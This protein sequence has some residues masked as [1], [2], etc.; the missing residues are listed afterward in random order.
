MAKIL[1]VEDDHDVAILIKM[2]L[3][4]ENHVVEV[5]GDGLLAWELL[6]TYQYEVVILDWQLPGMSGIE[7]CR[8]FRLTKATTPVLMLTGRGAVVDRT[9]GL[10][11]GADDYLTKPFDMREVSARVRALVRRFGN[12]ATNQVLC[13]DMSFDLKAKTLTVGGEPIKLLP[14]ELSLIEF[15]MRNPNEVFSPEA[16]LERVWH[17]ESQVSI[18][19]VYT[20]IK[21]L[22]SKIVERKQTCPIETVHGLGYRLIKLNE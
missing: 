3:E 1:L 18:G 16:L 20:T 22:R 7:I 13:G 9:M 11:T 5:A 12:L 10:D 8:K 19:T 2:E 6:S 4:S 21:T 17:S 14:K 15:F